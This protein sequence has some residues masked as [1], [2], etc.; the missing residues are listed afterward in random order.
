MVRFICFHDLFECF[1][2]VTLQ[3]TAYTSTIDL[4]DNDTCF[5]QESAINT[6]FTEFVFYK[7]YLLAGK[8]LFD[9]FL[10]QSCFACTKESADNINFC[11][12]Y[13]SFL[14]PVYYTPN[15]NKCKN[16]A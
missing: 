12:F 16:D 14:S 9:Q 6:D 4:I 2:E 13:T 11:H 1:L 8:Y 5:L 3:C 10:D 7:D 15:V